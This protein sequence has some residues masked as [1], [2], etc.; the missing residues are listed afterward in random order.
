[1]HL[2]LTEQN[3]HLGN[4]HRAWHCKLCQSLEV[5]PYMQMALHGALRACEYKSTHCLLDWCF[6]CK[7]E[8]LDLQELK[9][10]YLALKFGQP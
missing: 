9:L 4:E 7:Q 6:A 10:Y 1:M 2:S 3:A 8:L 5:E